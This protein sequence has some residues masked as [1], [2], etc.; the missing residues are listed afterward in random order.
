VTLTLRGYAR[1]R[2]EK[3]LP[4]GSPSAVCKALKAGRISANVHGKIDTDLADSAWAANTRAVLR[5]PTGP[6]QPRPRTLPP[7]AQVDDFMRGARWMA[8]NLCASARSNWPNF[9]SELTLGTPETRTTEQAVIITT[10][11]H[12]LESWAVDYIDQ[13]GLPEPDFVG[14]G[15]E[16]AAV[17]DAYHELRSDWAGGSTVQ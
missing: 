10:M 12:L 2:R 11:L 16:S 8:Q 17:R 7:A 5:L 15:S 4:G 13:S 3:G 9:I 6:A 14:F 1:H